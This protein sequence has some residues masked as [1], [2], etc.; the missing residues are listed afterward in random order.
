L[1]PHGSDAIDTEDILVI[2][3]K[4]DTYVWAIETIITNVETTLIFAPIVLRNSLVGMKR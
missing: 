4:L 3:D 1:N 2:R